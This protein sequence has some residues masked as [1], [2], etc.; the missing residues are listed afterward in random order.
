VQIAIRVSFSREKL[1]NLCATGGTSK[2]KH[3]LVCDVCEGRMNA[4]AF[5]S[6]VQRF[7]SFLFLVN[8]ANLGEELGE[9]QWLGR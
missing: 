8:G 7:V 6:L 5:Q 1:R 9:N 3:Y 4:R 2:E